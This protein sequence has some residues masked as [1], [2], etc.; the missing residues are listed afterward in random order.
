MVNMI[1]CDHAVC[2]DCF[3]SHFSIMVTE[4][5]IKHCN[6][7]LCKEPDMTSET[8]D[9]DLYLQL[10]SGLIQAHMKKE[11]YDMFTQKINEHTMMKDPNFRWCIKVRI[12]LHAACICVWCLLVLYWFY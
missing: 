5:S 4:K 6:C 10:F 8:I 12:L 2:H 1:N 3:V 7:P 11:E 9:M